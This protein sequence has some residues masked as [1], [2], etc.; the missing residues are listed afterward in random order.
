MS[1][2][3]YFRPK[4]RPIPSLPIFFL[5]MGA[6]WVTAM[7]D[8]AN[9]QKRPLAERPV[10]VIQVSG[11]GEAR[12]APDIAIV[13]AGVVREAKTAREA[14]TQN[15]EAMTAIIA[16]L[17][18]AGIAE[19]DLQTADFSIQPRYVYPP[20]RDGEQ[21]EP[22][23]VGYSVSN[24]LTVRI[25]NIEET[26]RIL[27]QMVSLGVNSDGDIRFT[28]DD[29][30]E[31]LAKARAEAVRNA[32]QKA[33]TLASAAGVELGAILEISESSGRPQPVTMERTI[34]ASRSADFIPV[35]GGENTYS[36]SV[37]MRWEIA[38]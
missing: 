31:A 29:P 37:Q 5:I 7:A 10:P 17:K 9:A 22:R 32:S 27:D 1:P 30:S 19:S 2:S 34:A 13:S 12:L 14:L 20:N 6:A 26:G 23:I 8:I 24:R 35:Q 36:V 16:A 3:R 38:Q 21:A 18:D 33:N 11:E 28:N 15:N 4:S 25:R